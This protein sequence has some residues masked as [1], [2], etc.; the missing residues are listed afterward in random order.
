M[1]IDIDLSSHKRDKV[2]E[3]LQRYFNSI[4][5]EIVRVATFGTETARSAIS[6]ACRGLGISSDVGRHLSSL[7]PIERGK[8]RDLKTCY[9]GD[10]EETP[11]TEFVNICNQY[12]H[13][14][15][16]ET[17]IEIE[18][19][20]NKCSIHAAGIIITNTDFT[21]HNAIMVAPNGTLITAWSLGES[22]YTGGIK[23]DALNTKTMSM[24]Q[25]CV[26]MLVEAGHMEWQ[27]SLRATYDKYLLPE[28]IDMTNPELWRIL[29]EGKAL[30][31]FQFD[32]P[33]GRLGLNA[34]KPASLLE[35]AATNTLIR[36]MVEDGEQPLDRYVRYRNNINEWYQDMRD[37]GL[38]DEEIEIMKEYLLHDYG[39]MNTQEMLMLVSQ[40]QKISNFDVPE[41]NKL[42]KSIA[43]KNQKL[44]EEVRE[45][46]YKKGLA[47]GCRKV[48]LDYIWDE[49][50]S[51][52][53][54]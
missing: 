7:I 26:E 23:Y 15:L 53:K 46:F 38:N 3:V 20:V 37:Y 17:A 8:V 49:Q 52:S 47:N 5:G 14:K 34:V 16:I 50:V 9:Y 29:N 27:G 18:G 32:S 42:R 35:V 4:G 10:Q 31:A 33:Q 36:L 54:G 43:K 13:L 30:S 51:L 6:T 21:D 1:D 41:S 2:F 45:L 12:Q 19:L 44:Y 28:N 24:I 40:S 25:T 48:F 39:V 22:E 11:I